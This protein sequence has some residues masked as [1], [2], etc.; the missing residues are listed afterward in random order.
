MF[1]FSKDYKYLQYIANIK[2]AIFHEVQECF[3]IYKD[4]EIH[5]YNDKD[6]WW[7]FSDV[8]NAKQ[9]IFNQVLCIQKA[10]NLEET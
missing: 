7:Q 9:D 1:K 4:I 10:L 5:L 8:Y 2:F 6:F 3:D